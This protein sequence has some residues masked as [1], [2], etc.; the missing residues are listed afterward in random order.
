MSQHTTRTPL[1]RE[2][3]NGNRKRTS[4]LLATTTRAPGPRSLQK[5][6]KKRSSKASQFQN[7]RDE[8]SSTPRNGRSGETKSGANLLNATNNPRSMSHGAADATWGADRS[9][10]RSVGGIV[11]MHA[12]GAVHCKC[13]HHLP[14]IALSSTEAEFASMADAGKAVLCLRSLLSDTGLLQDFPTETRADDRGATQ[15][16]TAQQPTRRTRHIDMKQLVVLQWSDEDLISFTDCPSALLTADSM[17]KQSGRTKFHQH[18]D[19][20][21]GRRQPQSSHANRPERTINVFSAPND[22]RELCYEEIVSSIAG[23]WG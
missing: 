1:A 4:N 18:F 20:L 3:T 6:S 22:L 8:N 9:H 14:T 7:Y 15:M 2:K 13:R 16:A 17:T 12:G 19:T 5:R 21:M 10:R 11:F 23:C